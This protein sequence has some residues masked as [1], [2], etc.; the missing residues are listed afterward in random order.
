MNSTRKSTG[1]LLAKNRL[2]SAALTT[3]GCLTPVST[4]ASALTLEMV[5]N[6]SFPS[7]GDSRPPENVSFVFKL[8]S[9][10]RMCT[11]SCLSVWSNRRSTADQAPG[12][13]I[14]RLLAPEYP[15]H[16]EA[17]LL[18]LAVVAIFPTIINLIRQ[19]RIANSVLWIREHPQSIRHRSARQGTR[20]MTG[21]G[22]VLVKRVE[23]RRD[24]VVF[25][26]NETTLA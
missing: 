13:W 12:L 16:P 24:S 15:G 20:L 9:F 8:N 21:T 5:R 3:P 26:F 23:I 14:L 22:H 10:T 18:S 17:S 6:L 7:A 11:F 1:S 19:P 4:V 2:D 25:Q